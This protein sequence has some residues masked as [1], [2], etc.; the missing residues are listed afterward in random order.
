MGGLVNLVPTKVLVADI[1]VGLH[2]TG[3]LFGLT[4][5]WDVIWATGVA[6]LVVFAL[7]VVLRRQITSGVPGRLQV[8]WEMG[9]QAVTKQVEGS[10]GPR[11]MAVI[12]LAV[13]LFVFILVCNLFEILG[14]G[15]KYEFL[16][17]PTSDINLPLAMALFVI[18]LVHIASVRARGIGGYIKH[19]LMQPFPIYLMPANLFINLVEEIAK[20]VTLALRLF[21]NLF[22]GA[23]MLSLIAALGAWKLGAFPI[24][25]ITTL[26]FNVIWKLFDVFLIGPIQAF[27]FT[28][29]TILY[30]DTAMAD[31]H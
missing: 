11:G 14:V 28:L 18:V 30:F 16:I 27:I 26:I 2:P 12:P 25:D 29:L 5:N 20:P 7:G 31:V 3:K 24:G 23:L 13:T 15:S 10:I 8:V 1:T 6:M 21:G 22:S 9:V 4:V 17:V 19:Y